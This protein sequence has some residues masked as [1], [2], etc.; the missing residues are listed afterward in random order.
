VAK[1]KKTREGEGEREK[2]ARVDANCCGIPKILE[3]RKH[4]AVLVEWS[5]PPPRER[6]RGHPL[7][8]RVNRAGPAKRPAA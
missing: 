6:E 8:N 4:L 7:F 1:K 3:R 2:N 5:P